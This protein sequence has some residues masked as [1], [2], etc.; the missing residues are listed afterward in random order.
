MNKETTKKIQTV[1]VRNDGTITTQSEEIVCEHFLDVYVNEQLVALL[2]CT[3]EYLKELVIGRLLTERIIE[4]IEDIDQ[5]YICEEKRK[6]KVFLKEQIQV[7]LE[8]TLKE[9]GRAHV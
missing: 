1:M 5:I 6:A 9:I 2:V 8:P 4:H 7:N 3:P